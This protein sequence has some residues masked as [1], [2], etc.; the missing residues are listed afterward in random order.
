MIYFL[1]QIIINDFFTYS[2][3]IFLL[4]LLLD[5]VYGELP[6]LVHP[7]VIIGKIILYLEKK[8]IKI[9][10]RISG[11][12]LILLT[13]LFI[14][15]IFILVLLLS[16]FNIILFIVIS[17]LVLSSTFSFKLLLSSSYKIKNDLE[18]NIDKARESLSFLVSRNTKKLTNK[19][20]ISATIETLSENITDSY[21]SPVF[22]YFLGLIILNYVNIDLSL[23]II[24]SITIPLIYRVINTLD[25]MVGYKNDKYNLIG[26]YP[27]IFDD[28]LNFIPARI[29]GVFIVLTSFFLN[30]NPKNSYN[31]LINDANNCPSPNSGYSMAPV[32]GALGVQLVKENVYVI[33]N[34]KKELS[35]HDI[36]KSITLSKVTM[37]IFTLTIILI[38]VI[39]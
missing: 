27:A 25:A 32:A 34:K 18:I 13:I 24:I 14:A 22:Y 36:T 5:L 35:T 26:F 10:N 30:Y 23:K 37:C 1:N 28:V 6:V 12:F 38:M 39:L 3:I 33:G 16:K 9:K 8:L 20:I 19:L 2:L 11:L 17:T 15:I 7:V 4:S 29:T 31:T 21:I